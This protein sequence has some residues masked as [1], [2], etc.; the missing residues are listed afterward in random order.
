MNPS[1][2]HRQLVTQI[3]Y[4]FCL[5]ADRQDV[6]GQVNDISLKTDNTIR[7]ITNKRGQVLG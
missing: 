4:Q 7:E 5:C 2:W 6:K 3:A 1:P